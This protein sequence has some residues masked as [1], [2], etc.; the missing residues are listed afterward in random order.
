MKPLDL[1]FEMLLAALQAA[2][3]SSQA[4]SEAAPWQFR[5]ARLCADVPGI[6]PRLAS[7]FLHV[8]ALCRRP[9]LTMVKG[10]SNS[11]I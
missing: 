2:I 3:V 7:H 9:W 4:R 1:A 11:L 10:A 5:L 8:R 6:L